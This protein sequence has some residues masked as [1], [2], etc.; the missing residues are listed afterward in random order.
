[1][2]FSVRT[3]ANVKR[4]A[5]LV[6][7]LGLKDAETVFTTV[8]E[9]LGSCCSRIPD[10]E[11]GARGYWIRWQRDSFA[12][13]PDFEAAIATR[14]LPG[15]KDNVER[16]FFRL[17]DGAALARL[18][19]RDLGYADEAIKSY[20]I[21]ARLL[22]QGR[23]A[24]DTRFQVALPTPMALLC[25]FM[26]PDDRL[27]VESAIERAMIRDLGR[28]QTTIPADRLSI[29]WDVCHEVVGAE[30]GPPLP[31]ENAIDGSVERVVGLCGKAIDGVEL[32]IRLCY[33]DPGHK[34]VIE[35]KRS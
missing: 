3:G 10:G 23:I 4:H 2:G 17:K 24:A 9:I 19:F 8:S 15:Y 1:L 7:S 31:Y 5:H 18:E 33:G 29:Q 6:G 35:P 34:H 32:G 12:S 20:K 13:H 16:T 14:S 25:G 11:T 27:R 21:F 30:G 22:E 26:I 28:I